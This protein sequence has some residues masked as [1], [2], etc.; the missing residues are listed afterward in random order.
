LL[1]GEEGERVG[2]SG[3]VNDE[4][5]CANECDED[6]GPCRMY[7]LDAGDDADGVF[8]PPSAPITPVAEGEIVSESANFD[9]S[10]IRPVSATFAPPLASA[11]ILGTSNSWPA[12]EAAIMMDTN[13]PKRKTK[14]ITLTGTDNFHHSF[15]IGVQH[16][17]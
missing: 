7:G 12:T 3:D 14:I 9:P 8:V 13:V 17:S 1:S 6:E 15:L 2:S 11:W 10:S 5:G 16:P 4:D